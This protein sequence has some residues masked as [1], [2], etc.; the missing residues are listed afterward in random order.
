[1]IARVVAVA[2]VLFGCGPTTF[3]CEKRTEC[4]REQ[5]Q[6]RCEPNHRCSYRDETCASGWRYGANAG[7]PFARAC[8]E[9]EPDATSTGGTTSSGTTTSPEATTSSGTT[10]TTTGDASSSTT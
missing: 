6:G 8:V 4:V 7:E 5:M 9:P 3:V 2:T 10:T 1:M